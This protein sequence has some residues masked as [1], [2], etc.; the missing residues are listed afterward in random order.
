MYEPEE[1]T[2]EEMVEHETKQSLDKNPSVRIEGLT[3]DDVRAVIAGLIDG[4][5]DLDATAREMVEKRAK[6]AVS[7]L[8]EEVA[9]DAIRQAVSDAIS[10]GIHRYNSYNGAIES[11]TTIA[12]MVQKELSATKGDNYSSKPKV[13]VAQAV[14]AETVAAIFTKEL[15]GEID[16]VKKSFREQADAVFKAKLIEGLKEAIGLK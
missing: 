8:T 6:Q 10:G 11:T 4:K 5:Y 12:E 13:T 9:R 1:P 3:A 16:A 15:Q 14:V 7:A 2:E